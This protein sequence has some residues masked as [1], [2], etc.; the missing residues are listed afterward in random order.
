VGDPVALVADVVA[1][2][3]RGQQ[4]GRLADVEPGV[5]GADADPGLLA[6][7]E[8]PAVARR[9][10]AAVDPDLEVLG[11]AGRVHLEPARERRVGRLVAGGPGE[12][13]APAE[14][15]DDQGGGDDATVG[16]HR[17]LVGAVLGAAREPLDLGGLEARVTPLPEQRAELPVVEGGEGPGEREAR[18]AV[19]RV[20]DEGVEALTL[21]LHQPQL[22]QPAGGNPAG[23]GLALADLVAVDDQ[24]VGAG[25]GQLPRDHQA[26]EARTAYKYVV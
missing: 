12:H 15:V 6:G 22:F 8:A 23:G 5:E 11:A 13:P 3:V 21:R 24:H 17:D 16:L 4:L 19:R 20:D 26:G 1:V 14:R 18:I 2:Q 10:V 9:D 7:R 25:A